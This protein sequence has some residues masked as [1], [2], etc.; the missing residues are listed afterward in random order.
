MYSLVGFLKLGWLTNFI[1]HSVIAGFM[2]GAA[3]TIGL[4]QVGCA[5]WLL[6]CTCYQSK[7]FSGAR[8][9]M[10]QACLLPDHSKRCPALIAAQF[11]HEPSS[12][13]STYAHHRVGHCCR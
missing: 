13:N 12:Y 3:I 11:S 2:S 6:I 9:N 8:T 4:S 1:S 7:V 5:A 10:L